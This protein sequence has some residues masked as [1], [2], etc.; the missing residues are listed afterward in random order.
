MYT[1]SIEQKQYK[2]YVLSDESAGSQIEVVPERGGIVTSWRIN[3]QEVFYLDTERFTHPDLSVRGGNPILFPLCG[4]L[5]NDTYDIDGIDYK[6]KQH[7]FA[8]ESSWSAV[9]QQTDDAASVMI[10]LVS[11]EKTKAVY[12]FDFHLAFTYVLKGNTLEI[13][14]EY[15]NLSST[16]MPFSSGFH[17]YF[18]CGDK[19]QIEANIPSVSYEDNRTKENFAF[20][21]K[22]DF[23]QDEIDSVFGNLS[24]RS[25]SIIDRDRNLKIAI[26]YDDFYTYLVFWT[27]KGKDFY[28]LEPWSATRNALNT[29]EYL[30]VLEPNASCKAVVSITAEFF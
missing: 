7:G 2:T 10:E 19:N 28:C 8:R 29:K 16:P 25:T 20:D 6:I 13:H 5:P 21:G 18:L 4:N 14:Q 12:P 15:K 1:V 11:N 9:G 27:V 23:D 24:S 30:T 17:P 3:G 22:F 26:D